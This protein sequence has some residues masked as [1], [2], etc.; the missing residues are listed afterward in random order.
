MAPSCTAGR[1]G[2]L[3]QHR[4]RRAQRPERHRRGVEDQGEGQRLQRREADQDQQRAGDRDRRAE[5]GNTFQQT[6]EAEPDHHQHDAPVIRQVVQHPVAERVEPAGRHRDIV[7]QQRVEH[8][9]HH[10]P[11]REHGARGNAVQRQAGRHLPTR[12]GD[13]QTDDQSSQRRLPG[14]PPQHTQHHQDHDDR[15]H[16]DQKRQRQAVANRCEQLMKHVSPRTFSMGVEIRGLFLQCKIER[17]RYS[18]A[19][20]SFFAARS[21]I[22][23]SKPPALP[24]R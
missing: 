20:P 2:H 6:A 12:H 22:G 16:G 21:S 24:I 3:A 10:R 15:Q 11:Q 18:A 23:T 8:D 9:P 1:P 19:V 5:P 17:S 7:E 4:D 13:H 14:R